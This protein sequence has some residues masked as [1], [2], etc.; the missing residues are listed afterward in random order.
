MPNASRAMQSLEIRFESL[1][2]F[3]IMEKYLPCSRCRE[4]AP[5]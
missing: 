2:A 4:G 5:L 1:E 3:R